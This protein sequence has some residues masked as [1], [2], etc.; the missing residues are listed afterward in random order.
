M[1]FAAA[2]AHNAPAKG[3]AHLR[4]E[5]RADPCAGV[6]KGR[7]VACRALG[8]AEAGTTDPDPYRA[9][10][11]Y[12]ASAATAAQ[13]GKASPRG[14]GYLVVGRVACLFGSGRVYMN[15]IISYGRLEEIRRK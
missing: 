6:C 14:L 7:E 4:L 12:R 11:F 8:A 1:L 9:P 13:G 5:V 2:A 3:T 15:S 10:R